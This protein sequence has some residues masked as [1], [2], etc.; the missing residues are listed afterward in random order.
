MQSNT[1]QLNCLGVAFFCLS[2]SCVWS[3]VVPA[4][5][6]V[7]MMPPPNFT[8][9]ANGK[10]V[11]T[12]PGK[13][14]RE[15][16]SDPDDWKETRSRIDVLG[17]WSHH[18]NAQFSDEELARWLP[19]I[20]KW[21]LKVGFEVAAFRPACKT[22]QASYQWMQ[23]DLERFNR[24]GGKLYAIVLDGPGEIFTRDYKASYQEA[25]R[26]TAGFFAL[27][28]RAYP[29]IQ[30]GVVE[31]YPCPSFD[32]VLW[33]DQLQS[34]LQDMHQPGLDFYRLDINVEHIV[35]GGKIFP[36]CWLG[37]KK[38]EDACRQRRI[39]FSLI[40]N[41]AL[42]AKF[43]HP[44]VPDDR[45]YYMQAMGKA[46][47]YRAVGGQPDQWVLESWEGIPSRCTPETEAWTY[48][49]LTRDF[50][51]TFLPAHFRN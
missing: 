34:A 42:I 39:A 23:R 27:V 30:I 12:S 7:W 21:G 40:I 9:S 5:P 35:L 10:Q 38:L 33:L 24:F 1:F 25:A 2:I 4:R 26:E 28:R 46:Y 32:H 47:D 36:A 17:Y 44:L 19:L 41:D 15:L 22:G 18:F 43:H 14:W 50:C 16:F 29:G 13:Q 49:R 45:A 37:V 3:Q 31:A 20:G 6:E 11:T 48:T 51:R 8:F